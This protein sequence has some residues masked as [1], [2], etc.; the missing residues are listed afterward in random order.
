MKYSEPRCTKDLDLWVSNSPK[1]ATKLS[2]ALAKFGAPLKRDG[3]TPETFMKKGVWY[4]NGVAPV[5]VDILTQIKGVEFAS[6]WANRVKSMFFDIPE[7]FISLNDLIASKKAAGRVSDLKH[8][9]DIQK[10]RRYP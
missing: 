1:N 8:L 7:Y 10:R 9:R 6:A 3:V 2:H 5:R 4:Q